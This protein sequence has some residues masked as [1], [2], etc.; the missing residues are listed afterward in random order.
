[1]NPSMALVHMNQS[2]KERQMRLVCG[3]SSDPAPGRTLNQ[4]YSHLG[5]YLEKQ[6]NRAAHS[7][8]RG[9]SAIADRIAELFGTGQ[10]REEKL[11]E[12][13]VGGCS[14]LELEVNCSKLAKYALPRESARTQIQAFKCITTAVTRYHGTLALFLKSKHLRRTG[15]T[16]AAISAVWAR[17]DD[18]QPRE[19]DFYCKLAAASLFE[20]AISTILGNVSPVRLACINAEGC[21]SVIEQLLISVHSTSDA[22]AVRYLT[23]ILELPAF[24]RER[25]S[26]HANV[27]SKILDRLIRVL[28]DL[29]LESNEDEEDNNIAFDDE[30]IDSFAS[31]ILVGVSGWYPADPESQY[32]YRFSEIVRLLRLPEAEPLLPK[33][34]TL[35]TGPDIKK[36]VPETAPE[37]L[38]IVIVANDTTE[39]PQMHANRISLRNI[40][41]ALN[42]SIKDVDLAPQRN[43]Y[44]EAPSLWT[45]TELLHSQWWSTGQR[46][47]VQENEPTSSTTASDPP[48]SDTSAGQE[49]SIPSDQNDSEDG[50]YEH[51]ILVSDEMPPAVYSVPSHPEDFSAISDEVSIEDPFEHTTVTSVSILLNENREALR[52]FGETS[53]GYQRGSGGRT[54]DLRASHVLSDLSPRFSSGASSGESFSVDGAGLGQTLADRRPQSQISE[55]EVDTTSETLGL[56]RTARS[57][58]ENDDPSSLSARSAV[59]IGFSSTTRASRKRFRNDLSGSGLVLDHSSPQ[60]LSKATTASIGAS[61]NQIQDATETQVEVEQSTVELEK[62]SVRPRRPEGLDKADRSRQISWVTSPV[63]EIRM[64]IGDDDEG[65]EDDVIGEGQDYEPRPLSRSTTAWVPGKRTWGGVWDEAAT[66]T[67]DGL[68]D[69]WDQLESPSRLSVVARTQDRSPLTAEFDW[70]D[71]SKRNWDDTSISTWDKI[72]GTFRSGSAA[73]RRS[74]TNNIIVHDQPI[75]SEVSLSES[76]AEEHLRKKSIVA[77]DRQPNASLFSAAPDRQP[78][79]SLFSAAPDRQPNAPLFP[80]GLP[81]DLLKYQNMKLFPFPD[82]K[83]LK[84]QQNRAKEMFAPST[85]TPDIATLSNGYET[86]SDAALAAAA[87]MSASQSAA[88]SALSKLPTTLSGVKQWLSNLKKSSVSNTPTPLVTEETPKAKKIASPLPP[89]RT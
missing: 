85:S 26:I 41:H 37:T 55:K 74:R 42:D 56:H 64:P 63:P 70:E 12:L 43:V 51:P 18:T 49:S 80:A 2:A 68:G 62:S 87:P 69:A 59:V 4:V 25:S 48:M 22:I 33:S 32:W 76:A 44:I 10:Q 27:L 61:S 86:R 13:H 79:A 36:I 67:W 66:R 54:A 83:Q 46:A 77:P 71:V 40:G 39:I 9:P 17:S 35:A 81:E 5:V 24:W 75:S 34:S 88:R 3:S 72:N 60:I 84:E 57:D 6:A 45:G 30:G 53:D 82:M 89:S 31:A 29:G 28:E 50:L 58:A 1:M 21:F 8:G 23:G 11:D 38:D 19:W 47:N 15:N 20:R 65:D 7:W 14:W 78:N 52:N 73:G 16:E